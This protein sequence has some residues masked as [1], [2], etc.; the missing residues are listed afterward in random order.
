MSIIFKSKEQQRI[1][2]ILIDYI[3]NKGI[4]L[5]D[6]SNRFGIYISQLKEI[7]Q[8]SKTSRPTFFKV[9]NHLLR[10]GIIQRAFNYYY[11]SNEFILSLKRLTR[12]FNL[13]LK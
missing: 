10:L 9:I 2:T 1:A 3:N 5:E 6:E 8:E 11:L 4:R 13:L 12:T 7:Q